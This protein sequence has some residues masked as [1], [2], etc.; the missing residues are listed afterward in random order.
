MKDI[1]DLTHEKHLPS[2]QNTQ[3][4]VKLLNEKNTGTLLS[5]Y[6]RRYMEVVEDAEGSVVN[7]IYVEIVEKVCYVTLCYEELVPTKTWDPL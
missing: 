6:V 4:T 3:G 7:Y 2:L 5:A 1:D